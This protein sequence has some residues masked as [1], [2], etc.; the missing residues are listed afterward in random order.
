MLC[1]GR[2]GER[3]EE[4]EGERFS[5]GEGSGADDGDVHHF[6]IAFFPQ[7][8]ISVTSQSFCPLGDII[9]VL[10][11]GVCFDVGGFLGSVVGR[12]VL[13]LASWT[14]ESVLGA[15]LV[16]IGQLWV[17]RKGWDSGDLALEINDHPC[18]WTDGSAEVHNIADVTVAGVGAYLPALSCA[19]QGSPWGGRGCRGLW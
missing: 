7:L 13:D 10:G 4:R 11:F 8:C 5:S 1:G 18:V 16:D 9:G 12:G 15:C 14:R 6:W 19:L 3:R 17:L 2:E